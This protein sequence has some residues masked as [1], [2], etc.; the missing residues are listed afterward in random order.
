MASRILR[1]LAKNANKLLSLHLEL[2]SVLAPRDWDY[3][4]CC[5]TAQTE[6]LLKKN[7]KRQIKK[8]NKI[9]E[10]NTTTESPDTRRILIN[11]SKEELDEDMKSVLSKG[12]NFVPTP[13]NIP[14]KDFIGGIEGAVR[15]LTLEVAE[16]VRNE[17]SMALKRAVQPKANLTRGEREALNK[18]R[19]NTSLVVLPADKGNATVLLT[20]EEYKEKLLHILEDSAYR[21]INRDPTDSIMRKTSSLIR[22]SGLPEETIRKIRPEA[23][24]PPRLYGLPKIHKDGVPLRP[25]VSAINSPTYNLAKYLASLL[26][27]LVGHCEHHI[28]NSTE[29]V[30]ILPKIHL[31][32]EDIMVSFDVVSLFTRVPLEDTLDLLKNQFD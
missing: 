19:R 9:S 23:G 3:I 28:T 16:E 15:K 32:P 22:Q 21:L 6:I 17:V 10:H 8:F 5:T 2:A 18:L 26:S 14:Y 12:L 13:K 1:E 7:T 29:F 31:D 25:I 4:D 20:R 30:K 27:P 24:I 11:L